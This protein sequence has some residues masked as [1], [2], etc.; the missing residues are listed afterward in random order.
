MWGLRL[1]GLLE[2]EALLP[3][4][5]A[6][7]YKV[8]NWGGTKFLQLLGKWKDLSQVCLSDQD[9]QLLWYDALCGQHLRWLEWELTFLF[10]YY[11]VDLSLTTIPT[12]SCL[13]LVGLLLDS[14]L[15]THTYEHTHYTNPKIFCLHNYIIIDSIYRDGIWKWFCPISVEPY[16]LLKQYCEVELM[17]TFLFDLVADAISRKTYS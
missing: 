14:T 5:R 16:P 1:W 17:K 7:T 3:R 12:I 15:H 2:A 11:V 8:M 6:K 9:L 10:R 4:P 13:C